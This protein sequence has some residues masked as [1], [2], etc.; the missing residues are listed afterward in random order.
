MTRVERAWIILAI[1]CGLAE[2]TIRLLHDATARILEQQF[3]K[4]RR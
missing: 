1:T 3:Y 4:A 2:G